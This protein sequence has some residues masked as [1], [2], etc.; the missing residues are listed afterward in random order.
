MQEVQTIKRDFDLI[1]QIMLQIGTSFTPGEHFQ[2]PPYP[3]HD[4]TVNLHVHFLKEEGMIGAY[5]DKDQS[6]QVPAAWITD[7]LPP[8]HDFLAL[9][10]DDNNWKIVMDNFASSH[11]EPTF[12]SLIYAL[13]HIEEAQYLMEQ[14]A[15]VAQQAEYT[16]TI[17]KATV[18]TMIATCVMAA[19]MIIQI[20]VSLWPRSY[21]LT[22]PQLIRQAV[23]SQST[24]RSDSMHQQDMPSV[25]NGRLDSSRISSHKK[26]SSK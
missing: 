17:K 26:M 18:W 12:D 1:R 5:C 13:S 9:I 23:P 2:L 10:R 16:A 15:L 20:I 11:K 6:G 8:G 14:R 4:L 19:A 21:V 3:E 24:R 22:E 25:P 7:I